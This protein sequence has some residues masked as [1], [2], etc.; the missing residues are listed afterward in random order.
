MVRSDQA[1]N[2]VIIHLYSRMDGSFVLLKMGHGGS[3]VW[4][5]VVKDTP[6]QSTGNEGYH[7]IFILGNVG[8]F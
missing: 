3:S 5:T 1:R 4:R 6:H 7:T 2:S 8:I